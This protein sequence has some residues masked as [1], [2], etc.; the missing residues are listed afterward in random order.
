MSTSTI[1]IHI[2][3]AM[4]VAPAAMAHHILGVPHYAYDEDYPQTPVLTYSV[5]AGPHNVRMSGFP[6]KPQPSERCALHVYVDRVDNTAPFQGPVTLTV[7]RDRLLGADPVV[8]GPVDAELEEAMFKFFP[9][10]EDEANYTVRIEFYAEGA[11][12]ILDLP[13]VA[14][15]P[16]SPWG[17][18]LGVGGGVVGFLV[19]IRALR[20]KARRRERMRTMDTPPR[21]RTVSGNA[22]S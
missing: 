19:I 11:P 6:G 20:I 2:I 8:Y 16:G 9:V 17:V 18:V 5:E 14:G 7:M 4:L 22:V 15:E 21:T 10:F 12:W 1:R 3:V 13:M